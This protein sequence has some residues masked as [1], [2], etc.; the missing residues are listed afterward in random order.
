MAIGLETARHEWEDALRRVESERADPTRYGRLLAQIEVVT[1]ELRRRVGQS[2]TLADLAR[3]YADAES[4]AR[5]AVSERAATPGWTR[6][7]TTVVAA[8]FQMYLR[9]ALDYEP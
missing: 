5:E 7:L 4:W 1:D 9:G 8:A 6:D 3:A 2:F